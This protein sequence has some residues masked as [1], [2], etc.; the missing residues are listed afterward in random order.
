MKHDSIFKSF[1][2]EYYGLATGSGQMPP[3]P[4]FLLL[5]VQAGGAS[6]KAFHVQ[7]LIVDC[8]SCPL[9]LRDLL[10]NFLARWTRLQQQQQQQQQKK[11]AYTPEVVAEASE[12]ATDASTSPTRGSIDEHT[13]NKLNLDEYPLCRELISI[14][15]SKSAVSTETPL[16][17]LNQYSGQMKMEVTFQEAN[18][19]TVGPFTATARLVRVNEDPHAS[20]SSSVES[21]PI[22]A[23]ATGQVSHHALFDQG[24]LK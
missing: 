5:P 6:I 16:M 15:R 21:R 19:S 3:T 9:Q 18:S 11:T 10:P 14:V 4:E 8:Q 20:G 13:V 24:S 7:D 12:M 2:C 23:E 17:V 22:V 1:F